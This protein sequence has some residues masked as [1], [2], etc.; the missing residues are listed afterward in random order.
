MKTPVRRG[1]AILGIKVAK[2]LPI[3]FEV[4]ATSATLREESLWPSLCAEGPPAAEGESMKLGSTVESVWRITRDALVRL[5]HLLAEAGNSDEDLVFHV[6][7][8]QNDERN[9]DSDR[10]DGSGKKD[11]LNS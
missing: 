11:K 6:R 1:T 4:L 7:R 2:G 10:P 8:S 3:G 9:A 5:E